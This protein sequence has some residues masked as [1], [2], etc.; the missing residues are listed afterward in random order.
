[1]SKYSMNPS[2]GA[3]RV[4]AFRVVS[5]I[6]GTGR[7]PSV[8][9][10]FGPSYT[11]QPETTCN[12][13]DIRKRPLNRENRT[14]LC[15]VRFHRSTGCNGIEVTYKEFNRFCRSLRATT[16][17]VQWGGAHVWK[18]GGKVFAIGGWDEGED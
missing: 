10:S 1:M 3:G 5:L 18:V 6:W 14:R 15:F 16:H 11:K 12:F 2:A 8:G 17:V 7:C 13:A 4:G 9:T